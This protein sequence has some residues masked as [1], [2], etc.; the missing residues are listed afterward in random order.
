VS[1][2]WGIHLK[3]ILWK[4]VIVKSKGV[5]IAVISTTNLGI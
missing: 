2:R 3:N 1:R 5:F 4:R